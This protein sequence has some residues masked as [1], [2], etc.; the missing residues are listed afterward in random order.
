M[1]RCTTRS[2]LFRAWR[3]AF[4]RTPSLSLGPLHIP[5]RFA[6]GPTSTCREMWRKADISSRQSAQIKTGA[7]I[8]SA[9]TNTA[10]LAE[11]IVELGTCRALEVYPSDNRSIGNRD[12]IS[13]YRLPFVRLVSRNQVL[14][15]FGCCAIGLY[16]SQELQRHQ[17]LTS[18]SPA[19]VLHDAMIDSRRS[20]RCLEGFNK[21]EKCRPRNV[22]RNNPIPIFIRFRF[23]MRILFHSRHY[24]HFLRTV[25]QGG[26]LCGIILLLLFAHTL[27]NQ[28]CYKHVHAVMVE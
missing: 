5:I 23:Y 13:Q 11:L 21:R 9:P 19:E 20:N 15:A 10:V 4:L 1:R 16:Q 18:D 24:A 3:C 26:E 14:Q 17:E 25:K 6:V 27:T 7:L 8:N 12:D 2:L 28:L 22:R